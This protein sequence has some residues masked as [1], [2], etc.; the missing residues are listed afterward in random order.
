MRTK[1]CPGKSPITMTEEDEEKIQAESSATL[2][3]DTI[4]PLFASGKFSVMAN[5]F[6][7]LSLDSTSKSLDMELQGMEE[8]GFKLSEIVGHHP[9]ITELLK[10]SQSLA[11]ALARE[12]WTLTLYDKGS[13]AL[14][15]GSK[16]SRL[17]GHVRVNP[18]KLRKLLKE[19]I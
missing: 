12:G 9:G 3:V 13:K 5:G 6:P 11:K 1:T 18:L 2:L 16:V 19:F 14:T 10:D 17:T 4:L 8:S 15:I 7:A